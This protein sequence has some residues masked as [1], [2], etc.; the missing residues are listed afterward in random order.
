MAER[1]PISVWIW[2]RITS[3]SARHRY[4][5]IIRMLPVII[6]LLSAAITVVARI[7]SFTLTR[8]IHAVLNGLAQLKIDQTTKEEMLRTVPYLERDY[9]TEDYRVIITDKTDVEG[10]E[11]RVT[12]IPLFGGPTDGHLFAADRLA[13]WLGYRCLA[14]FA[15]VHLRDG[16]VSGAG[17][18]IAMGSGRVRQI[19]AARSYHGFYAPPND[20][21]SVSSADDENPRYQIEGNDQYLYVSY[22]PDAPR[23]LT[24]HA[25]QIDLSCFWGLF[26]CRDARQIAPLLLHDKQTIE[27]AALARLKSNDPCPDRILAERM[28]FFLDT[29]VDLLEINH[30]GPKTITQAGESYDEL[31][32]DFRILGVLHKAP[33]RGPSP[34][35]SVIW[36]PSPTNPRESIP[37]PQLKWITPGR[38]VL[39]FAGSGFDSC[40]FV[41]AT[42]SALSTVLNTVP[43][44]KRAED[45]PLHGL[46]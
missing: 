31:M 5:S 4:I 44:P 12:S 39:R 24:S 46:L 23:D 7:Y 17:Y 29:R 37:N 45:E 42:P 2:R 43:A 21:I 32:S 41:P 26:E 25:F 1:F 13:H 9:G 20:Q 30:V 3:P 19:I 35:Y 8:K 6:V 11:K 10:R 18:S 38:R 28:R 22:T 15:E 16:K 40:T 14:F 33:E 27:A 36:I 34:D